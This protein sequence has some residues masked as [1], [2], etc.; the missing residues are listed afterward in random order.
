MKRLWYGAGLPI[1]AF[2]DVAERAPATV[3]GLTTDEIAA[4]RKRFPYLAEYPVPA[5]TYRGQDAS[6][7]TVAV[8][9]FVLAHKDVPEATAYEVVKALLDHPVEVAGA[10][11][12]ASATVTRNA[13]ANTFLPFHPGAT[14]YYRE[15]G[16]A[17]PA[18]LTPER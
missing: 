9:N 6:V 14:R 10:Y 2:R 4:F 16:V 3:F 12:A 7:N 5:G 11:P 13:T 15:K 17:L 1:G 8:W 18:A